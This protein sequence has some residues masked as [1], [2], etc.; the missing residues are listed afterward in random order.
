MF[1]GVGCALTF[2]L[3][4]DIKNRCLFWKSIIMTYYGIH[5]LRSVYLEINSMSNIIDIHVFV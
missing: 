3:E 2:S 4:P 5:D 1:S